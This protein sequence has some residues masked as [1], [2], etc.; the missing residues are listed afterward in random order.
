MLRIHRRVLPGLFVVALASAVSVPGCKKTTQQPPPPAQE[1]TQTS[2]DLDYVAALAA[3][4]RFCQA[5]QAGNFS[6]GRKLLTRRLTRQHPD[7]RLRDAIAGPL[8]PRHSAYEVSD[9][10]KL[11]PGRIEFQVRL[12]FGYGGDIEDRIET[13][14]ERMVLAR[15]DDGR[16][17]V[18]EFPIPEIRVSLDP[19]GKGG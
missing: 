10:K 9:G 11:G 3:A 8:N 7:N 13:G 6:E 4:N 19:K 2:Y 5:W 12:F 15:E 16:W 1:Q 18:D 17:R 14:L